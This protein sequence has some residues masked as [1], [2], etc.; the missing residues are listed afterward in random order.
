[1]LERSPAAE[2]ICIT[3]SGDPRGKGR[4]RSRIVR[5]RNKPIFISVYPDPETVEYESRL[6]AAA[7]P[8]MSGRAPLTGPLAVEII[9]CFVVPAS[10]SGKK[11][12]AALTG[13]IRPTSRPDWDN[14]AKVID[15]FNGVVW[16]DDAQIVEGFVKKSYASEASLVINVWPLRTAAM[17]SLF[18]DDG[19]RQ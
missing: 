15:A 3:V 14:L 10:W 12:A 19:A 13:A 2:T 17:P 5:P 6:R 9:A 11:T 1:M 7:R 16:E 4:P 18:E 8:V